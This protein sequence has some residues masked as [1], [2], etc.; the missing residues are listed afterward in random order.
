MGALDVS[1]A[2][3]PSAP[4]RPENFL[5]F[6]RPNGDLLDFLPST[7]CTCSG[8][9]HSTT[10]GCARGLERTLLG[11]ESLSEVSLYGESEDPAKMTHTKMA[12]SSRD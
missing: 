8:L 4:A 6:Q 7:A 5:G 11:Y 1:L 12:L 3:T 2:V 9:L 10:E